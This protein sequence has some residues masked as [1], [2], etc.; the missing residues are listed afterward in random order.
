MLT[1]KD[2]LSAQPAL[3]KISQSKMPGK[4]AY[5]I[6]RNLRLVVQELTDYDRARINLLSQYGTLNEEKNIYEL[7]GNKEIFEGEMAELLKTEVHIALHKINLA[8]LDSLELTPGEC[9]LLD[10]MID[11]K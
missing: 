10:W 5:T 4:L 2:L 3:E 7:N 9:L 11:D 8:N 6:S 1:L